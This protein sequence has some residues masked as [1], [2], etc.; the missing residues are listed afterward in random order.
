MTQIEF[1]GRKKPRI[2]FLDYMFGNDVG[3]VVNVQMMTDGAIYYYDTFRRW[4]YL[5]KSEEGTAFE[6]VRKPEAS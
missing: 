3:D 2:R 4:C 5:N 1:K 6:W